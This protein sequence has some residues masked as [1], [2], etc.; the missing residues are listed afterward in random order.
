MPWSITRSSLQGRRG[1]SATQQENGVS[2]QQSHVLPSTSGPW[3]S[4]IGRCRRQWG[5]VPGG[6]GW[7]VTDWDSILVRDD[8]SVLEVNMMTLSLTPRSYTLEI[9]YNTM[10]RRGGT[11]L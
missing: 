11:P 4:Q 9:G 8:V 3:S 1:D 10:P 5:E 6:G 7:E 2:R